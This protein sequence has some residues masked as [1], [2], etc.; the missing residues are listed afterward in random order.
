[1]NPYVVAVLYIVAGAVAGLVIRGIIAK[2]AAR[3]KEAREALDRRLEW[4]NTRIHD[5]RID[6]TNGLA[7]IHQSL[8]NR[9]SA[10]EN[11]L[12]HWKSPKNPAENPAGKR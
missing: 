3:K 1:M 6:G 5:V 2:A 9:L 4:L 8:H 12:Q 11:A 10:A 7:E